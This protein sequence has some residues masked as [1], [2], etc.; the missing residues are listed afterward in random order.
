MLTALRADNTV[1]EYK[2]ALLA[3]DE[4]CTQNKV[5][6]VLIES[7]EDISRHLLQ[8]IKVELLTP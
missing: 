8:Y 3:W 4:W 7:S 2:R 5:N 6:L 1:Y